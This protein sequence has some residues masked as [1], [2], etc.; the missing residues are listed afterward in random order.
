MA[1]GQNA[2]SC[3]PLKRV[4][5]DSKKSENHVEKNKDHFKWIKS[6]NLPRVNKRIS[7]SEGVKLRDNLRQELIFN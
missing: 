5:I 4:A 1:Y 3:D 2:P 6:D 7:L